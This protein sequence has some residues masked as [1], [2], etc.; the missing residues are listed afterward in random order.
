VS[1]LALQRDTDRLTAVDVTGMIA[2]GAM[3]RFVDFQVWTKYWN[4]LFASDKGN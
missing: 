3:Y 2:A 4:N 1:H